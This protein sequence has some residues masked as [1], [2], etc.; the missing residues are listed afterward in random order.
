[1]NGEQLK[2]IIERSGIRTNEMA[3]RL[4]IL[5]QQL[6]NTLTPTSPMVLRSTGHVIRG[7]PLPH[8]STFPMMSFP[9][10]SVTPQRTPLPTYISAGT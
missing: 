7:Q 4:G 9:L 2:A 6:D 10:H 5:P 3:K 8:P 1:M